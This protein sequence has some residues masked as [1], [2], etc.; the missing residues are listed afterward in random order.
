ME[1]TVSNIASPL[2]KWNN[3][4]QELIGVEPVLV[5]TI[6]ALVS[7]LANVLKIR[8]RFQKYHALVL[9]GMVF[10]FSALLSV[11]AIPFTT[12]AAVV[13]NTFVLAG[14]STVAHNFGKPLYKGAR[15]YLYRKFEKLT[16]E[17]VEAQDE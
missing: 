9:V 11:Y 17:K 5:V 2:L 6:I 1:Q 8:D 4:I 12:D 14:V 10:C 7:L 13:R 16:G 3:I 15:D